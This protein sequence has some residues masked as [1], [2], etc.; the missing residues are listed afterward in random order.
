MKILVT[1][2]TGF[3]G[4]H[5]LDYLLKFKDI[6]IIITSSN[7]Y[8]LKTIYGNE[9]VKIIPFDIYNHHNLELNLFKIFDSP[10]KLIHLAWR[11]LP[12]YGNSFHVTENLPKD[13]SFISNLIKNGL[14]DITITGTCFEYGMQEGELKEEM[15]SSPSN[16]Y[17]LAKDTLR[18]MLEIYQTQI[19]FDLKWVRL[20]YMYGKGQNSNS[21]IAQL[22]KSIE[23]GDVLFNMSGGVQIRDY[24][25][26]AQIAKNIVKIALQN[27]VKGIIN[28]SSG[29]PIKLAD[30]ITDY[31]NEKNKKIKLNLGFYPYSPFEPMDFW[32]N[33]VKLNKIK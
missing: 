4:T 29:I 1:G 10:D 14:K 32:G 7:E 2:A 5:V 25:P 31:L 24:L 20:F 15:P 33:N 3:I 22:D 12:N 19:I 9:N 21:L 23:N 18:R 30:L 8:K 13:F 27:D 17:A 11:G 16:Y 6:S 28:N 26:V